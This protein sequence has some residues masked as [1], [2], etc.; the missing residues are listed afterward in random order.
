MKKAFFAALTTL[1]LVWAT[2]APLPARGQQASSFLAGRRVAQS[3]AYGF[4][5]VPGAHVAVGNSATGAATVTVCP[6]VR[7]LPD[8][9][10]VNLFQ[11]G[12]LNP[13]T[14]D[15]GTASSETVTPTAVSVVSPAGLTVEADQNCA[16]I[17]ATFSFTHA[18]SQFTGQVRSGTFGLQEAINDAAPSGLVEV[19]DEWGG[20][21]AILAAAVPY[22]GVSIEDTRQ[23]VP[24]YW[25]AVPSVAT[26]YLAVPTALTSTTVGFGLNGANTTS[27]TYTGTSTYFVCVAYVDVAGQEGACS[28]TFSGLTA[29]TG[30]TNQIG[31]AAPAA[32]TGAVGYTVYISLASGSYSLSYQVPL[33]SSVCK[34]T[35][36]ESVTPACQVVNTTYN[37]TVG[38]NAIVSA[39]TVNTSPVDMQLGGVSGTLLT[40]NPNGRTAY[41]YAPSSHVANNGIPTV[42]MPFT[43]AG[44]GSATPVSIGTVNLP[45]GIWNYVGKRFRVCGRFI[46]TDVN[47]TV[48]NINI[49]WDAALSNIA[50]SPVKIGSLAATAGPGTAAAYSGDFCEEF[51]TTVSGALA[52]GSIQPGFNLF[53]Y[54][55]TATPAVNMLGGDTNT[56]AIG[57]LNLAGTAG[58][59]TRLSI[60]HT[61]TTGNATPQ[62]QSLTIEVL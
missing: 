19:G 21:N 50:G 41:A 52:T 16:A 47:S 24:Q 17:T 14:F 11:N 20:T 45:S 35:L 62:L 26:T 8:G 12:I 61:N 31:I 48:Q 43:I 4:G 51:T 32:S 58:F 15:L 22:V 18:P 2:L 10:V 55:L 25:N 29:G 28:T 13:V 3:Y 37:Q 49:Y 57:L 38:S 30:S 34:L 40:G 23:G 6:A 36:V 5:Q 9:R 60:V 33:S 42:A 7:A 56:A 44:I 54:F 1:A 46:N 39:L 53:N 27:G 59:S